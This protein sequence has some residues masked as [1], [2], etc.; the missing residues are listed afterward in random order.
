MAK[1]KYV[2]PKAV[3]QETFPTPIALGIKAF[4]LTGSLIF[5]IQ[6]LRG[7]AQSETPDKAIY[8]LAILI[9]GVFLLLGFSKLS[10]STGKYLHGSLALLITAIGTAGIEEHEPINGVVLSDRLWLGFG[11]YTLILAILIMPIV[12]KIIEWRTLNIAWKAVLSTLFLINAVLVI[13]SFWQSAATVV[14]ADH[15]E[16]VINEL[17]APVVGYWPYSDFIPQY[18]SF[19]G[20]FLKPFVGGMSASQISD[21]AFIALT[22]LSFATLILGVFIAWNAID[23]RSVVLA[24]GLV[25]PFTALTQFPTRE[26]YLG[27]I[28]ALL[29]G[30]SIRI[31][32]GLVLIG[33][34]ILLL[35]KRSEKT[36][37]KRTV[38]FLAFGFLSGVTTWQSQD[39][40]IAAVVTSFLVIA[41]ASSTRF[42]EIKNTVIA[43]IGFVP[44]FALYPIIAGAAGKTIDFKYF[45]FFARQFGS[46]FGAERI[47]TPGPVLF[48]LPLIVL[49][50]VVHGIYVYRSKKSASEA[51]DYSLNALI[52]F[53]FG[54]WSLFGFTYYL[55]RSYA[56]GQMQILFLPLSISLAAF[57][58]IL[59]KDPIRTLV[60]GNL[61]K[62]FLFSPRAMKEKNFAWV[63]PL[64]LIISIPFASLLLTPNPSV[65]MKRIDEAKTAPR[66]PKATIVASVAD[67]KIAAKYAKDLGLTIGFFGAS[68]YYVERE[69][70]V[71]SLSI[72]NSP[73]DLFM[74]QTTAQTSCDYINTINPDVI[75]VSDEGTNLFQFEGKTLCNTYIQQDAPGVRSGHFAVR[76][77]K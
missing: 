8:L 67:A 60:F 73:F 6:L 64:L 13:P 56:S 33:L 63:L 31:F 55:N 21:V 32:P 30:L 74:S 54:L 62:S 27:S 7:S 77:A 72:L 18:Q 58:G 22:L 2:A 9:A 15:S 25:I 36:T 42:L 19:Y 76:V 3:P 45:L 53:A 39:F 59:I 5:I 50:V 61:Q 48:I 40:G 24:T 65:E 49:L 71:Q 37:V 68:S 46:G 20:F 69:T 4:A 23:R 51:G 44:G 29:S 47:R 10:K 66:W 75:V 41:Y 57:V 1:K 28:A 38:A 43:L 52:G 11:P 34:L 16:Y 12:F 14:D 26:G 17:L 70:G 35:R